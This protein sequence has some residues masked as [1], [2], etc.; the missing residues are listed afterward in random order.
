MNRRDVGRRR[1]PPLRFRRRPVPGDVAAVRALAH[2]AGVFTRAER[3]VAAELLEARLRDGARKSGYFFVFADIGATP[4]GYCAWGPIP[5]TAASFDLYWIVVDPASQGLGVGQRLLALTEEAVRRGGGGRL[6]VETSS[7]E[8][9]TRTRRFYRLAGYRQVA[10]L[11]HF[12]RPGDHKVIFCKIL[13]AGAGP[14]AV[15]DM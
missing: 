13:A 7:S 8:R 4:V 2:K 9:Y 15:D 10:R 5:M 1:A 11:E 3:A 12:Y 14:G 6:Y